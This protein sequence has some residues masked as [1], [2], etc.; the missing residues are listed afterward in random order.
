MKRRSFVKGLFITPMMPAIMKVA[1]YL[2]EPIRSKIT[3]IVANTMR[4]RDKEIAE[5]ITNNNA[6]LNK[7]RDRQ[8]PPKEL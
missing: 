6:L 2:P 7:M 5:N 8:N 1:E 4:R 3:D